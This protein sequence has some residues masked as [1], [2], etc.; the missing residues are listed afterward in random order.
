MDEIDGNIS[1]AV[2]DEIDGNIS[3]AVVDKWMKQTGVSQLQW[4]MSR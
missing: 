3:T 4:R 1:T 2:V